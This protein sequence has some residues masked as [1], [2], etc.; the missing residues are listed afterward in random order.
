MCRR[1]CSILCIF[2]RKPFFLE[3]FVQQKLIVFVKEKL[4]FCCT[5]TYRFCCTKCSRKKELPC[6]FNATKL[7]FW[8]ILCSKLHVL[9]GEN[10]FLCI[11]AVK[12]AH[13]WF[14]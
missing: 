3:H 13:F 12:S 4:C 14:S 10:V 1:N 6:A 8:S 2:E 9:S 7:F 5:K 11:F